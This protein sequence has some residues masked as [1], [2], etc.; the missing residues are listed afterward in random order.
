MHERI[1]HSKEDEKANKRAERKEREGS[2]GLRMF[3]YALGQA[4]VK[5]GVVT[6]LCQRIKQIR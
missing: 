4:H 5:L 3:S 2:V 1:P 6:L